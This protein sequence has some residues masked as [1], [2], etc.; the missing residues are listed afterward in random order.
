MNGP[1]LNDLY[2]RYSG[3]DIMMDE[4][5]QTLYIYTSNLGPP[6][7]NVVVQTKFSENG[8]KIKYIQDTK[9]N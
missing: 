7:V 5:D 9:E 1:I 2:V 4:R 3:Y 8:Y 6:P